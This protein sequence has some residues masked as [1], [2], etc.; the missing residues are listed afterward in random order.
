M[1]QEHKLRNYNYPIW[2]HVQVIL[3]GFPNI[4]PDQNKHY[5]SH[6]HD[7]DTTPLAYLR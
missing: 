4:L 7:S 3:R 5:S 6:S 1:L 2:I